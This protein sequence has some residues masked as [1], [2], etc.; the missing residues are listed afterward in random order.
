MSFKVLSM[1]SIATLA[2]SGCVTTYVPKRLAD[3]TRNECIIVSEKA[4]YKY[5]RG[6]LGV[7]WEEGITPSV[8]RAEKEDEN[9]VFYRGHGR[10]LFQGSDMIPGKYFLRVGGIWLPKDAMQKAK[11][12]SYFE[13]ESYSTSD[14]DTLAAQLAMSSTNSGM[15]VGSSVAGAAIGGA[16]VNVMLQAD[17]GKIFMWSDIEDVAFVRLISKV[18]MCPELQ[19]AVDQ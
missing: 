13:T 10:P 18:K 15:S 9:G 5:T 17:V 14:V 12:Y 8:F 7:I 4:S 16:I 19:Q 3:V 11:L 1:I 6:L 2:I